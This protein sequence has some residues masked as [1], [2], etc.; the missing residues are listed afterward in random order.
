MTSYGMTDDE[1]RAMRGPGTTLDE[2]LK[3]EREE[4]IFV[5]WAS[6]PAKVAAIIPPPL[7]MVAPVLTA[8]IVNV[9]GTNFGPTYR[10]AALL[11]PASFEGTVGMYL[12]SL[13]VQGAGAEQAALLGR[14][15]AGLPKK[16]AETV[17][18]DRIEDAV[19]A[20]VERGGVRV[21]DVTAQIG[22]YNTPDALQIFGANSAGAEVR[23]P[24][25]FYKM[26]LDQI[27]DGSL[28][29]SR[30]RVVRS[31]STTVYEDWLPA[32]ATV[33]LGESANDPWADLPVVQVLGAG[34]T[35]FKMIDFVS[36]NIAD[37][38][39]DAVAPYLLKARYDSGLRSQP[40][41]HF[42]GDRK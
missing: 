3:M 21:V 42:H 41:R 2:G 31:T 29:F 39:A 37:L 28:Q 7:E 5:T 26:D 8:Y 9:D 18:V 33:T 16:F 4:G 14:E 12:V 34:Y 24:S 13:F 6:D 30:A 25:Y 36:T 35:R 23:G 32:T 17:R 40:T 15:M 10:E 1:V 20:Y 11:V 19:H 38:D 27:E 22:D